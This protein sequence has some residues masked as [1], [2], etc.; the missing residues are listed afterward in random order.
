MQTEI[1]YNFSLFKGQAECEY[2]TKSV[3]LL[4]KTIKYEIL[5]S[6]LQ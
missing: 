4:V 1:S 6:V 2:S 3:T 5:F